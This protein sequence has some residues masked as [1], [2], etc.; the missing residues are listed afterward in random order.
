MIIFLV[1]KEIF[2]TKFAQ[3]ADVFERN[4]FKGHVMQMETPEKYKTPEAVLNALK[5]K[6]HDDK[7]VVGVMIPNVGSAFTEGHDVF[8]DGNRWVLCSDLAKAYDAESPAK[9]TV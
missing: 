8:S 5:G 3:A 4:K 7:E 9:A 2:A 1:V 6:Q